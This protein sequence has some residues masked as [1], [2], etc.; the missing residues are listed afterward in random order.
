MQSETV[1]RVENVHKSFG[2]TKALDGVSL[3]LRAGR[4]HCLLG[5][6][7]SG[8]S[9][10]IKTLAGVHRADHGR[11][12]FGQDQVDVSDLSPALARKYGLHFVHQ[13]QSTFPA[14]PVAETL[15]IRE[16]FEMGELGRLHGP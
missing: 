10:L 16:G 9:T 12:T 6:N 7:G 11:L 8:K 5:G 13:Q 3:N 14:L 4:I 2:A 15:R 1:L